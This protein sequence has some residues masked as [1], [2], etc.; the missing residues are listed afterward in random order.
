MSVW[1]PPKT[2]ATEVLTSGDLNAQ[3]RD[4]LLFLHQNAT[5]KI[6]QTVVTGTDVSSILITSIPVQFRHMLVMFQ[7]HATG[8]TSRVLQWRANYDAT[9]N[10]QRMRFDVD[11]DG[12]VATSADGESTSGAFGLV[13]TRRGAAIGHILN[14]QSKPSGGFTTYTGTSYRSTGA[15]SGAQSVTLT[16][17]RWQSNSHL[18]TLEVYMSVP[19]VPGASVSLY[20]M[21]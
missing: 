9:T 6:A 2:W 18:T 5:R 16:G 20:G 21:A 17:G 15:F 19:F 14:A 10:Y 11:G 1:T 13:G 8:D 12:N 4:N 7:G 3:V